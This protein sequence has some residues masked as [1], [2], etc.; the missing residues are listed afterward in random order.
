MDPENYVNGFNQFIDKSAFPGVEADH[1]ALNG[2]MIA[3][4]VLE[5][6]CLDGKE[7]WQNFLAE[8][9]ADVDRAAGR[10]PKL[11]EVSDQTLLGQLQAQR[12]RINHLLVHTYA[13][14]DAAQ[15]D[16]LP[17]S[18]SEPDF[19]E[20]LQRL[21][22]R[23]QASGELAAR[24][25][26]FRQDIAAQEEAFRQIEDDLRRSHEQAQRTFL[27]EAVGKGKEI[28]AA[29]ADAA[30]MRQKQYQDAAG[31]QANRLHSCLVEIGDRFR[32]WY[33]K[34]YGQRVP[35]P[36]TTSIPSRQAQQ[37]SQMTRTINAALGDAPRLHRWQIVEGQN[38]LRHVIPDWPMQTLLTTGQALSWW[39]RPE[40]AEALQ[41]ELKQIGIESVFLANVLTGLCLKEGQVTISMPELCRAL[42]RGDE[43]RRS[44]K[45]R[46]RVECEVWRA[47][48]IFDALA[49]VGTPIGRYRQRDTK[50]ILDV[51]MSSVE[52]IIK[53]TGITPGQISSDGSAPPALFSYVCGP[54]IERMRNNAQVMT[55]FGDVMRLAC[56][57][58]GQPS[59]AWAKSI[60]LN[61]NQR[62]RDWGHDAQIKGAGDENRLTTQFAKN[63][64]R[65]DLLLGEN[66]Y[67][68]SPDADEI[69]T[70]ADP[71]RAKDYW[72]QAIS[73]LRQK[74]G[75]NLIGHYAE[76]GPSP[77]ARKGW[78]EDWLDQPLDIRPNQESM[79][80]VA[81]LSRANKKSR[82]RPSAKTAH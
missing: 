65:R 42:G 60:G 21:F 77:T 49:V 18:A 53:I 6:L 30:V 12:E 35:K 24:E 41:E 16:L 80:D 63:F 23:M 59:G 38:A 40:S 81:D 72:N 19:F 43:A 74:N 13:L 27:L 66:L 15:L 25:E 33:E 28:D 29:F 44:A 76:I 17:G 2:Y 32:A 5:D 31:R 10:L 58:P 51:T 3:E 37:T 26:A 4:E 71:G 75:P 68:A 82:R 56:I 69:L 62:W 73:I 79:V 50:E 34:H 78:K 22:E 1:G 7:K 55:Y 52:A 14:G 57:P 46:A 11:P 36:V 64:T 20:R 47:V 45:H 70:S 39:G 8:F 54:W 9:R 48:L 67:R 61:L